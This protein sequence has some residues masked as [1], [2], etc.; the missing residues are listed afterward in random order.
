MDVRGD[1]LGPPHGT[2]TRTLIQK[3]YKQA[4]IRT[5]RNQK[6]IPTP[7]TEVG[8]NQTN[9]QV[10]IPSKQSI[11]MFN[12]NFNQKRYLSNAVADANSDSGET[13]IALT[14]LSYR[15]A[16]TCVELLGNLYMLNW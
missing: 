15:R 16:K 4:K 14:V 6:K 9:N 13:T 11:N 1:F 5:R 10:L 12:K 3:R 7:K 8:K 2:T